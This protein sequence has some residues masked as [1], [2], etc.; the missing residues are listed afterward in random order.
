MRNRRLAESPFVPY[1]LWDQVAILKE[2]WEREGV[3]AIGITEQ[4]STWRIED[5]APWRWFFIGLT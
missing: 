5:Y 4:P 1:L 2:H 3:S